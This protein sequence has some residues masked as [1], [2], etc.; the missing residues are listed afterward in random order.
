[1]DIKK[2]LL[3]LIYVVLAL[4]LIT[5]L[6]Y[7][8]LQSNFAKVKSIE[9]SKGYERKAN[10]YKELYHSKNFKRDESN[11]NLLSLG[12][13][14]VNINKDINYNKLLMKVSIETQ[15]DTIDL[16]MDSQSVIRNDVIDSIMNL[17]SAAVTPVNVSKEIKNT[18]NQRLKKDAIKE[19]YL[20]EFIIQ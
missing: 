16:I 3:T 6:V 4:I 17:G 10:F 12:E 7:L 19:V 8:S 5:V 2:I 15:E 1:M 9:D 14:T 20:E 11:D 13:F 18:L